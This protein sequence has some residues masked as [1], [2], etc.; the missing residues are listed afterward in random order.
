MRG[1]SQ[2]SH[3]WLDQ[4]SALDGSLIRF[5]LSILTTHVKKTVPELE[6]ALQKVHELR[7]LKS[8][9]SRSRQ[10]LSS[11]LRHVVFVLLCRKSSSRQRRRE[12]RGGAEV[13]AV[14][15]Q[16]QRP[17]RALAGNVR[18]RSG[19]DGGREVAEG[20]RSQHFLRWI[21]TSGHVGSADDRRTNQASMKFP[22]PD[23]K[24]PLLALLMPWWPHCDQ[25][26][27]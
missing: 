20:Q 3:H 17:V 24:F 12:R 27:C 2:C 4:F 15:G 7:G 9:P 22:S 6:V 25:R 19:A 18:L 5:F 16:R 10:S 26:H 14:P 11:P 1:G 8:L 23:Q 13:P 21:E